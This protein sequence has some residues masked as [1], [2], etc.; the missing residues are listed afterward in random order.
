MKLKDNFINLKEIP[1]PA[2]GQASCKSQ[3]SPEEKDG[4]ETKNQAF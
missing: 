4:E 3:H 2:L 1:L